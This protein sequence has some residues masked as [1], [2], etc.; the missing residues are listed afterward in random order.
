[1]MMGLLV[2]RPREDF[3]KVAIELGV[4]QLCPRA[5][6]VTPKLVEDAHRRG[7]AGGWRGPRMMRK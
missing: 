4:R 1:M 7:F 2:D 3:A 5:D 6:L